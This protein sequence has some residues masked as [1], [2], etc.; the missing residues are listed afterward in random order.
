MGIR[1]GI[2]RALA[3]ATLATFVAG[4]GLAAGGCFGSTS[5][6][7]GADASALEASTFDAQP[8]HEAGADAT[9]DAGTEAATDAGV[10]AASDA[11]VD[12]PADGPG[13][14]T[15]AD[16]PVGQACDTTTHACTTA[17]NTAQPCHDGCCTAASGGTCQAGTGTIAC[18]NN[19]GL[20]ASC[21]AGFAAATSGDVCES[22]TGG[23]QC[24]CGVAGDCPSSSAG[25]NAV[26]KLCT[27][28]CSVGAPCNAGCCGT[29][30]T[31]LPGTSDTA[32][33]GTGACVDCTGKPAGPHC[34]P[35]TLICGCNAAS[36]C[37]AGQAC[38]TSTH[39]CGTACGG[40]SD[41][42]CNGGCC[43]PT[44][45]QCVV[46]T[47]NGACGATGA[48]CVG[49]SGGTP[50]CGAGGSCTT[51][52]GQAGDGACGAGTCCVGSACVADTSGLACGPGCTSCVGNANGTGCVGGVC[53]CSGP[54]DCP[55]NQ[56]CD[57]STS[58]CGPDCG[59]AAYSACNGGC[60]APRL[61]APGSVCASG[62]SNPACGN[63]G[64]ACT[65]CSG[66]TP[67]CSAGVCTAACGVTGDGTCG[68]GDCCVGAAC[69][70]DTD[71]KGCGPNCTDCSGNLNGDACVTGGI[72]GCTVATDCPTDR[73]CSTSKLQCSDLCGA[74]FTA[75]N[76]GCC[77]TPV[78]SV[79]LACLTACPGTQTCV[80]GKCQ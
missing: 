78:G 47:A 77:G 51:A 16:C 27:F 54:G 7:P 42:A 35:G 58:T 49:C 19:G 5:K 53:G 48:A 6:P 28:T 66:L 80:A 63:D 65:A 10:E 79:G 72:C 33:G 61:V 68:A 76:G 22:V 3:G 40:T 9:T 56:A 23:G 44:A 38:D 60:C 26:T 75:C 73:A 59:T 31:C 71:P 12:A 70:A 17:C 46:G 29:G 43:D 36:D 45:G 41:T 62:T 34:I 21:T 50:T 39:T 67:T 2:V 18:G 15:P 64:A 11:A 37:A 24:G 13:C 57:L 55:A 74:G 8:G 52:C 1:E 20:C 14:A 4:T 25:C 30:S 32:C 69:V